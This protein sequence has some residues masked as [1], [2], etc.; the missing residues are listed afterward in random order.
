MEVINILLEI[1]VIDKKNLTEVA[2]LMAWRSNPDIYK[3]FFL[4]NG[5]LF[6][7]DHFEFITRAY[8]RTD[9]VVIYNF[10]PIG[11][12]AISKI[13]SEYPEISIMIGETTLWGKGLA[14]LILRKFLE[15]QFLDGITRFSARIFD[16][17][18]SSI[19]LFTKSGFIFKES[20]QEN[21]QWGLYIYD[22]KLKE[23][24]DED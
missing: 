12:I 3:N 22:S 17:N 24:Y 6:W 8:N 10:R 20:I 23:N 11:H 16:Q 15:D 21:N 9:Y 7:D 4:Q 5:P 18:L 13:N 14:S 19:N 1:R 2:L